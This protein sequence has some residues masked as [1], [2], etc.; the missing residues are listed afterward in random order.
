[1]TKSVL[2]QR[3]VRFTTNVL[4]YFLV[5]CLDYE[6]VLVGLT[7]ATRNIYPDALTV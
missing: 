7:F 6:I 5:I 3:G 4:K 2:E 1:M